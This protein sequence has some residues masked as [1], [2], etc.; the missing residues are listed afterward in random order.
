[1]CVECGAIADPFAHGWCAYRGDHPE[2]NKEPELYFF[3]PECAKCEF[4]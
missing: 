4:G 1:V 3:C 2:E